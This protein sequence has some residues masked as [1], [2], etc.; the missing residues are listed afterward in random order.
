MS[1][2]EKQKNILKFQEFVVF[3][4]FLDLA[5]SENQSV[6]LKVSFKKEEYNGNVF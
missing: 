3:T 1:V 6:G 2:S 5:F 4:K